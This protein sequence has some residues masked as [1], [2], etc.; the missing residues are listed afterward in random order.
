MI[1]TLKYFLIFFF[2]LLALIVVVANSSWVIKKV[3]D[4]FA[5]EYK[6]SYD[7]IKGNV[8]TGVNITGLKYDSKTIPEIVNFNP[9][10]ANE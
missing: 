1:K 2:S 4:K 8:F 6:I 5:P 9:G 3:A 7:D 10:N